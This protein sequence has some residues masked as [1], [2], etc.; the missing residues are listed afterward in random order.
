MVPDFSSPPP[1][2]RPPSPPPWSTAEAHAFD[3]WL[4]EELEIPAALLM[5]NAGQALAGAVRRAAEEASA[6]RVLFVIG[7][8]N[9][10]GDGLVAARQLWGSPGLEIALAAPLGPPRNPDSPAFQ[11]LAP[12]EA[13]EV[14]W[15]EGPL[16]GLAEEGFGLVVD[17]LF[18]VGLSR[19]LAGAAAEAVRALNASG[20][21][22][23]AV[24]V[25]SGLDADTGT[26][27]GPAIRAQWTLTFVAPKRGFLQD[28]GPACCGQVEA[29]GIGV[30]RALAEAWVARRRKGP[31]L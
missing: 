13:L 24:D 2:G 16:E 30:S 25:P 4:Q 3:A 11:A 20:L 12:L 8:G 17:A 23:L 15:W 18:G 5:E 29:A 28:A 19:P 14:P 26:A 7:P 22:I 31:P 10:G 27:P 21:P 1:S 9:N 6:E